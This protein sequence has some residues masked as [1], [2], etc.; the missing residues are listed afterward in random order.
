MMA[1]SGP[2]RIERVEAM[3]RNT[4]LADTST[5]KDVGN[6]LRSAAALFIEQDDCELWR[7]IAAKLEAAAAEIEAMGDGQ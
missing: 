5:P 2:L 6:V 1:D 7:S 3:R 4:N